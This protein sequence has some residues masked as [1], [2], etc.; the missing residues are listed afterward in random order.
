M[1]APAGQRYELVIHIRL[2]FL[3]PLAHGAATLVCIAVTQSS[4]S[5]HGTLFEISKT[6]DSGKLEL[7]AKN[8]QEMS[9]NRRSYRFSENP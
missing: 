6:T 7:V 8:A 5:L 2:S 4:Q 3:S 1:G 9:Q